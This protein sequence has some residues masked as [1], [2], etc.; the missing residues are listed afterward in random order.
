MH[1]MDVQ[2]PMHVQYGRSV[3]SLAHAQDDR[4]IQGPALR[5]ALAAGRCIF[6]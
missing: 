2:S 1:G 6:V 5:M 4:D 3:R